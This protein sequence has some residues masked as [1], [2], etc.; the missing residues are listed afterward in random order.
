MPSLLHRHIFGWAPLLA[1]RESLLD[2]LQTKKREFEKVI[3]NTICKTISADKTKCDYS[4]IELPLGS[5]YLQCW[6]RKIEFW[7]RKSSNEFWECSI[8][9]LWNLT[10]KRNL[11]V[12]ECVEYLH[13]RTFNFISLKSFSISH[14]ISIYIPIYFPSFVSTRQLPWVQFLLWSLVY[15]SSS[16]HS[17]SLL[18]DCHFSPRIVS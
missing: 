7:K 3:L 12:W 8:L 17:E 18:Y 1:H 5:V 4:M 13:K 14:E 9:S 6:L 10:K 2:F 15:L 16:S 11:K